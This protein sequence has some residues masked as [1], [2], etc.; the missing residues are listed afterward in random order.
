MTAD[1]T[2]ASE[3]TVDCDPLRTV[4]R[5][6]QSV[7]TER[8]GS[9]RSDP[10]RVIEADMS[11]DHW[12][13]DIRLCF[14]SIEISFRAHFTSRIARL[15]A[16]EMLGDDEPIDVLVCHSFMTE[17]CNLTAGGLKNLISDVV[18]EVETSGDLGLP[19]RKPSFDQVTLPDAD[20]RQSLAWK[21]E[22][23]EGPLVCVASVVINEDELLRLQ[24]L[25]LIGFADG[26]RR[27][28]ETPPPADDFNDFLL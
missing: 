5:V 19:E 24:G 12:I 28:Y 3:S 26:L 21:Y 25:S 10:S 6:V 9:L 14:P 13:S 23:V 16:E 17:Y 7:A 1:A 8:L 27:V 11:F 2:A 20:A 15:F 4:L 18:A 22:T